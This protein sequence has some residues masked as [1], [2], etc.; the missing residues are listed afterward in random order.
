MPRVD[1]IG[2][3]SAGIYIDNR[4]MVASLFRGIPV[5]RFGEI[6]N[7]FLRIQDEMRVPVEVINDGDVTALAGAMSL[8]DTGVLGIAMGSSEAAGYV[9]PQGRI[10]GW[11]NELAFAPVDYSSDAPKDEWSGDVGCGSQY[12]S[13]QCVFRLA[14]LA[15]IQ[16]PPDRN[17]AEKL[18]YVQELLEDGHEGAHKIWQSM[19]IYLGYALAHYADFY[20]IK[21]VLI[22][23]RCTSGRGGGLILEGAN[24]VLQGEFPQLAARLQVQLPDERSRRVGQSIAAASLP[25]II[26]RK[27]EN[28]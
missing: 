27:Q 10:L 12:F 22:L 2:G 26:Q 25:A 14:P 15:G 19:G 23:G 16:I 4:P 18:A 21:H 9:D 1:A 5:E 17:D 7:L 8:E 20:D 28:E 24:R 13:Q 3:S 6:K 11:L